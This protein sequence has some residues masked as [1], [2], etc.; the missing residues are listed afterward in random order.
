MFSTNIT[1][2]GR[3]KKEDRI[4]L[5]FSVHV[6]NIFKL[7]RYDIADIAFG[8]RLLYPHRKVHRGTTTW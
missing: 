6:Y 4:V 8:V 3:L 1:L 2:E 7:M 5:F